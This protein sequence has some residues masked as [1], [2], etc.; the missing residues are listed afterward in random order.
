MDQRLLLVE[1]RTGQ[2]LMEFIS[3]ILKGKFISLLAV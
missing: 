1:Q 2:L 3:L